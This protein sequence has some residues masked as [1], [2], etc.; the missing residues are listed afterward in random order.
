MLDT[1]WG[2]EEGGERGFQVHMPPFSDMGRERE[3]ETV[4]FGVLSHHEEPT[5]PHKAR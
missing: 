3:R 1:A 5:L 2:E 4:A